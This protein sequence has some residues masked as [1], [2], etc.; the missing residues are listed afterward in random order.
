M[1]IATEIVQGSSLL[2][3]CN[4]QLLR[5]KCFKKWLIFQVTN[6]LSPGLPTSVYQMVTLS[7]NSSVGFTFAVTLEN[8][9]FNELIF[10]ELVYFPLSNQ[11]AKVE[12]PFVSH[13]LHL[14]I[15]PFIHC[16][17]LKHLLCV[18]YYF[19]RELCAN[20]F[21]K[22]NAFFPCTDYIIDMSYFHKNEKYKNLPNM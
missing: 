11:F 6:L 8:H 7:V 19:R 15:F 22:G 10:S 4:A 21:V 14:L 12:L 17:F 16:K 2:L 18:W 5:K 9:S 1:D 13:T 3:K 20:R